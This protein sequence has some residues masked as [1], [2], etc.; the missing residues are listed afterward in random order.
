MSKQL[1]GLNSLLKAVL[2]SFLLTVPALIPAQEKFS[3]QSVSILITG[4]STLHDW[5]EKSN[6]GQC[7]ATIDISGDKVTIS[8]FSFSM[9]AKS[10]KSE[11]TMMDNNTY[12]A[13]KTDKNPTI[14]LVLSSA[15]VT[16]SGSN[17]YQVKATGNLTIAGTTKQTDVNATLVYNPASKTFTCKGSK[18]FKMTEY[19]VKPPTVMMGTIK[20]G[21]QITITYN[22]IIKS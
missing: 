3:A 22:L 20:T 4:T 18:T 5:E 9:P 1:S 13:L 6:Q 10:L 2:I 8:S 21:D 14:S 19:G 7:N 15:V 16:P 17:T 12:K 11:H